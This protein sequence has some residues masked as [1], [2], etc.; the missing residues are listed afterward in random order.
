M[1]DVM[2]APEDTEDLAEAPPLGLLVPKSVVKAVVAS[3]KR[4]G[5]RSLKP[6]VSTPLRSFA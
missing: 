6:F 5:Q 4:R 3:A 2:E 1:A